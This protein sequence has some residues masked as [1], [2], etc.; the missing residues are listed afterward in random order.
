M[1]LLRLATVRRGG[2]QDELLA[3]LLRNLADEVVALLLAGRRPGGP[4]AGV[5]F[6]HDHLFWT[7]FD[8]YLTARVRLDEVDADNLVGVVVVH[9]GVAL[10]LPVEARLGVGPDDDGL[11]VEFRPDF[12]L[13][14]FAQV[15][16]ADNGETFNFTPL[17]QLLDNQQR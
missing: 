16:E 5:D 13:P 8:E 3:G 10:D 2:E 4:G 14:L 17:Q 1:K 12:F 9:A 15:W 11:Q 6:V 7:L